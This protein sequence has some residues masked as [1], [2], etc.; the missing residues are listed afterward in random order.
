MIH[1]NRFFHC[2]SYVATAFIAVGTKTS[3][4]KIVLIR[5]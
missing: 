1:S 5:L 4:V 3:I 2:I